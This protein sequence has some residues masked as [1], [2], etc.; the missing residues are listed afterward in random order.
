M[1][2]VCNFPLFTIILCLFSSVLC[3]L[4]TAKAARHW[5]LGLELVLLSLSCAVLG[6]TLRTGASFTYVM[7]EFP[8]PWGNELRAGA[9]EG[10]FA[11]GFLTVL[12]CS[13][14]GGWEF[15]KLDVEESK[16]NLFF[17]LI[18][19][20]TAAMM[21]LLWT[22]DIFTGYVFLEILT[23]SSCGLIAARELGRTTLA[24]IRYMI[25]NLLG[26]GLFLLGVVLL[27]ELTG[28]LLMLPMQRTAAEIAAEGGAVPLTFALTILTVGLGIK[29]GL[30]PF[31][32]WMPDTYGAS[33]PTAAAILSSLVSKAYIFLLF[34]IYY[35]AVGVEVYRQLPLRWLLFLLGVLGMVFG[36]FSA[37]RA[38]NINR[39]A[40]YS[41]AAQIG[42]IYMGLGMGS[43]LGFCAALFQILGHSVTKAL[44][45][46]TTPRLAAVSGDSLLFRNLQGSA[47]RSRS[48]GLCFTAAAL[49]MVGVPFFAGFSVKLFFGIAAAES[50]RMSVLF[51]VLL[52]LGISSVLNAV[53]FIRTVVRIYSDGRG[54]ADISSRALYDLEHNAPAD[55]TQRLRLERLPYW[56]AAVILILCNLFLGMLA[57][58]TLGVLRQG[59]AM[60]G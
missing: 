33:T 31:Y 18:N 51:S 59:L 49:S 6:Y 58:V 23:L 47:L 5:T 44:L 21:A 2:F 13:V 4:L 42:Y 3:T 16:Q 7:G 9:L 22:N 10:L 41:S 12:L 11:V 55:E 48:A 27:Y 30:F 25:M 20:L 28:H 32:F 29:S 52:A 26:S 40:A 50:D 36:S 45:F 37:I 53:Y 60:F 56:S 57:P 19:L 24:A 46:I 38:N 8:A 14:A 39:M 43:T 35:R 34:K 17:S 15:T 1:D 54:G